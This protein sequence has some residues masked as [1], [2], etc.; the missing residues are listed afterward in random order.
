M[1]WPEDRGWTITSSSPNPEDPARVLAVADQGRPVLPGLRTPGAGP[2]GSWARDLARDIERIWHLRGSVLHWDFNDR[3]AE[4]RDLRTVFVMEIDDSLGKLPTGARW[5]DRREA[6]T[7][8]PPTHAEFVARYF[9]EASD[10][11]VP[12]YRQPWQKPGWL[13]DA[14]TWIRQ[15]LNAAGS[16]QLRQAEQ[17]KTQYATTILRA[18]TSAGDVY[19]KAVPPGYGWEP[20]ATA[21]LAQRFSEMVP[22]LVAIDSGRGWTLTRD[23]GGHPLNEDRDPAVWAEALHRYAAMQRAS[24][25]LL[26]QLQLAHC[27]DMSLQSL[28]PAIRSLLD[29][30]V[31]ATDLP[32]ASRDG[33]LANMERA[34]MS[35]NAIGLPVT[36]EHGD[37]HPGNIICRDDQTLTADWEN[38]TTA[39]PFLGPIRL[40]T[41]VSASP[42]L[43]GH[44][45]GQ[46]RARRQIRDAY[47]AE[48]ADYAPIDALRLAFARSIPLGFLA[49]A[50]TYHR[51]PFERMNIR[52]E[53][54]GM[55]SGLVR[56]AAAAL[57]LESDGLN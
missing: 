27:P 6:E 42:T 15:Q 52:W 40:L 3:D 49:H 12:P 41:Y 1:C 46:V 21:V 9:S 17:L 19:F 54:A 45:A 16:P 32:R 29:D 24:V 56:A 11:S 50:V 22:T 44:P 31:V 34:I 23:Y 25:P 5:L 47:L 13:A 30:E 8:D 14:R 18:R 38:A 51:Y 35:L 20:R 7:I 36:L 33:L 43:H 26:S 4:T 57:V 10:G 39:H 48:W 2:T 53:R 55:A 28:Q 37:L